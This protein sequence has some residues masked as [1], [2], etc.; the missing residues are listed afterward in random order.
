MDSKHVYFGQYM[1]IL[2]NYR[3]KHEEIEVDRCL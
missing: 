1:R 3:Y 2:Y